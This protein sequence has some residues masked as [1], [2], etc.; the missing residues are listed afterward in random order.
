MGR[1]LIAVV[2][3][4][5]FVGVGEAPGRDAAVRL[6]I[7]P[8]SVKAGGRVLVSANV[9]QLGAACDGTIRH[10]S[11]I[12]TLRPKRAVRHAL[13]WKAKIPATAPTGQWTARVA[14]AHAGSA[15]AK[16]VVTPR[17]PPTVPA[18][19][20]VVKSGVSAR[21]VAGVTH[22]GWGV[23]L[24]NVSPDEDAMDVDV[25]LR[26]I[27]ASGT[28]LRFATRDYEGVPADATYYLGG[29]ETFQ[30]NAP[31]RVEVTSVQVGFHI[32]TTLH[33]LAPVAD[34]HENDDAT[35]ARV[36]GNFENPY[37]RTLSNVALVTAVCFDAAGNVIG[38]GG[39]VLAASV[40]PG[41]HRDF[42][43]PVLSLQRSQIASA[44]VSVEPHFFR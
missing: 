7:T 13:S 38:G 22:A 29:D 26:F 25:T 18:K 37:D 41:T 20:I 43:I 1:L 31:T 34:I 12:V 32:A 39:S 44:Q 16:L 21:T 33:R 17:T 11:K 2:F 28:N 36:Q 40:A 6:R 15:T 19:I 14:C 3:V 9:S 23:V 5:L 10:A 27:D 8:G 35:S 24:K 30:G 42:D 4:V